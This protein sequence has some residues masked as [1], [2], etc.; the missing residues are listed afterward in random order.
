MQRKNVKMVLVL[1]L[2]FTLLFGTIAVFADPDDFLVDDPYQLELVSVLL[3]EDQNE[4]SYVQT[5]ASI[6]EMLLYRGNRN[7]T[8]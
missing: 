2:V 6:V 1:S 3:E 5:L 8:E 4:G 7:D